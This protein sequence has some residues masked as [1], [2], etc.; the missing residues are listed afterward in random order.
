MKKLAKA[1]SLILVP[2]GLA[3]GCGD[4]E[5]DTG[6]ED[7]ADTAAAAEEGDEG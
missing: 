2:A 7:T 5:E 1:I 4:K 3:I 6:A